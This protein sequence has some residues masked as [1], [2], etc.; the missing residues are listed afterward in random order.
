MHVAGSARG[1]VLRV[2]D[3]EYSSVA[4]KWRLNVKSTN[5]YMCHLDHGNGDRLYAPH[6][7]GIDSGNFCTHP[8]S[9][10][11]YYFLTHLLTKSLL[12]SPIRTIR[13][14]PP[15]SVRL[16]AK[17]AANLFL[18]SSSSPPLVPRNAYN[19]KACKAAAGTRCK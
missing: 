10:G 4:V 16:A 15:T 18:F 11:S 3:N 19:N 12:L 9:K 5:V 1:L 13:N 8:L 6:T 2:T 14:V 17:K 7:R